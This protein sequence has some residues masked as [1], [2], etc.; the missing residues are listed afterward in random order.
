[1][2]NSS[3]KNIRRRFQGYYWKPLHKRGGGGQ[4]NKIKVPNAHLDKLDKTGGR[5]EHSHWKFLI[6]FAQETCV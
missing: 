5:L 2:K 4:T 6:C 1:V 3:A